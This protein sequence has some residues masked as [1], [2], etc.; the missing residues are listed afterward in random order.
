MRF[1]KGLTILFSLLSCA[2]AYC[3]NSWT[4]QKDKGGIRISSRPSKTSPFNDIRVEIDVKGTIDQ[5][6]VILLDI[7]SY[8]QWA[9]ATKSCVLIKQLAPGKLIYFSE[10]EV[11]WPAANRYYFARLELTKDPVAHTLQLLSTSVPDE[12]AAPKDLVRVPYSSGLWE[13][14]TI[15]DK[16]IHI[17]Y[18]LQL[19]PGGSL[20]G[21][22]LNLFATKG[23]LVTF[24]NIKKK[25][26]ELNP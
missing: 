21:W 10:I 7:P 22:M 26:T 18:M 8:T 4:V 2:A 6:S 25:M 3:Q 19:N 15:A 20:P 17:D 23:P 16:S 9:Y 1:L 24:Q 5:L 14:T 11:P 13:V 12:G